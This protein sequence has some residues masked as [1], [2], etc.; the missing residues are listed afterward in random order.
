SHVAAH[1]ARIERLRVAQQLRGAH[2]QELT[3][4]AE[5]GAILVRAPAP[6]KAPALAHVHFAHRHRP[7]WPPQP[8]LH[9]LG[10]GVRLPHERTRRLERTPD[11]DLAVARQ[12]D[13][14][15][16]L[17]SAHVSSSSVWSCTL[18]PWSTP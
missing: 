14:C 8:P 11:F 2:L 18:A 6:A 4:E 3:V 10:R 13:F 15:G 9:Q 16:L 12:C 7:S 17:L 1:G 5:L